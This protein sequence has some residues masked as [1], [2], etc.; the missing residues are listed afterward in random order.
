MAI[1]K[2]NDSSESI[3]KK[4]KMD[5]IIGEDERNDGVDE[6]MDEEEEEENDGDENNMVEQEE[7]EEEE[8]DDDEDGDDDN[9]YE[10]IDDEEDEDDWSE[11][12]YYSGY[13]L[14]YSM[15]LCL[16]YD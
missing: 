4:I 11:I 12:F 9:I 8:T 16:E 5:N 7:V 15:S 2:S 1:T 10:G 6:E 13:K 3:S 14:K